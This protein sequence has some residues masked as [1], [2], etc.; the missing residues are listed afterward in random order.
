MDRIN[1]F[2]WN[3]IK[4][5]AFSLQISVCPTSLKLRKAMWDRKTYL[6]GSKAQRKSIT[7]QTFTANSANVR[8]QTMNDI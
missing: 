7:F 2:N 8:M 6:R 1:K 4:I 5:R 3:K